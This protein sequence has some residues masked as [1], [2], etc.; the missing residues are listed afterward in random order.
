MCWVYLLIS[1]ED[2]R[3]GGEQRGQSF[4]DQSRDEEEEVLGGTAGVWQGQR[5]KSPHKTTETK[6]KVALKSQQYRLH[7]V[8]GGLGA[9]TQGLQ[10]RTAALLISPPSSLDQY[11][12]S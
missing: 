3:E 7:P 6:L 5:A 11:P 4:G 1:S 10:P 8:G 12:Q 2:E 9:E